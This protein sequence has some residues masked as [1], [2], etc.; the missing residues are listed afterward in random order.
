M[1]K[2]LSPYL[3]SLE[4]KYKTLSELQESIGLFVDAINSFY[5]D[6]SI[7]LDVRRGLTIRTSDGEILE[8]DQLSSGERQLLLLF[9]NTILAIEKPSLVLIDEPELSLNIKWQRLLIPSLIKFVATYPVQF[10]FATHSFEIISKYVDNLTK[11]G[12]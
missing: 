12:S 2:V 6:K 11:L 10:I 8:P 3:D 4:S 5:K 9:C 7:R 1:L